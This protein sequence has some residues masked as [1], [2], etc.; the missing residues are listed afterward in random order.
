MAI[1]FKKSIEEFKIK[2]PNYDVV[3]EAC[4]RAYD[5]SQITNE[6]CLKVHYKHSSKNITNLDRNCKDFFIWIMN[7]S[8]LKTYN[9]LETLLIQSI[10]LRYYSNFI[11]PIGNKKAIDQITK[12]IKSYLT[13]QGISADTKNNRHIIGFL[14]HQSSEINAFLKL[15]I[16]NGITTNW[17]S[18]FEFISILRNIIAHQ[19]TIINADTHNQIKSK[20]KDIFQV[21]FTLPKDENDYMNLCPKDEQFLGLISLCNDFA[22]NCVKLIFGENDLSFI[23][24]T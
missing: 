11:N 3:H 14:S 20:S 7:L 1:F 8:L 17:E 6:R 15:P 12:E 18:F 16:R 22:A 19:G 10:Q 9:A 2:N 23:G 4:F 24:M 5:I 13:T 21:H